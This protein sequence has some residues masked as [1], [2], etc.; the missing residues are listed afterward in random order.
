MRH[1]YETF[2][3]P[4]L[5]ADLWFRW[6][7]KPLILSKNE[8]LEPAVRD[9]FTFRRSWAW[10]DPNGWFGDGRDRWPWL[11]HHPQKPGW[12]A[13][14]GAAEQVSVNVAQHPV[15]N[16]GR[17]FHA[18]R[19]PAA[20]RTAEGLNFAEQW[21]RAIEVDPQFVF[22]TG[23]N[24]WI[25]QRFVR[26][27]GEPNQA[28][29]MLGRKLRDGDTYF[30]DLYSA[31]FSRDVEPMRGGHGDNYYYQLAANVRRFKGVRPPRPASATKSI[32]IDGDF[33]QWDGVG[34]DFVDDLHDTARRRH[35]GGGDGL[36]Y[37]NDTG[38]N[39]LAVARVARD[40]SHVY[41]YARTRE[42]LTAPAGDAWMVLLVDAD[43]NPKTGWHGYDV[44]LNRARRA[45]PG[46]G[47]DRCGV[48]RYDAADKQWKPTGDAAF[49]AAGNELHLA[50]A[51]SLLGQSGRVRL[52]F[53]W[54]DN[55]SVPCD[56]LD[57]ID[58]GDV[59]PNGRFNYRY[60]E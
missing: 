1:L 16:I 34:P 27:E 24:E 19:Q 32:A 45:G 43:A 41:F 2:Y 29:H 18:G 14:P 40:A 30:V 58:K 46:G 33:R 4:G 55:V 9:F 13:R 12:H 50:V 23:W 22:V 5:H 3:E 57:F 39:D 21:R 6:Q 37:T 49:A 56:P 28:A 48:E 52:D 15:S 44:A 11:D 36:V 8:G 20:P 35:P 60:A 42:P 26:R 38:R 10:T 59:A 47:G 31:E 53:K 25:A 54:V 7:G 51:R 17:S